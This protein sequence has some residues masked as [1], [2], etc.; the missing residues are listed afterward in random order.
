MDPLTTFAWLGWVALILV[1][2]TVEMFTHELT[3]AMLGLGSVV[4]LVSAT[5]GLPWWLQCLVAAVAAV[6]LLLFLRPP[7]LARMRERIS[8]VRMNVD[9]LAGMSGRVLRQVSAVGGQVR[10]Q[11]GEVWT[12]RLSP[13]TP[14]HELAIGEFVHVEAI[15]GAT[16]VVTASE[17]RTS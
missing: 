17:S 3:F 15:D 6:L 13:G 7:L 12:A 11:N 16:A 2:G 1:F 4:G 9:A 8:T 5:T 14:Q 10:L